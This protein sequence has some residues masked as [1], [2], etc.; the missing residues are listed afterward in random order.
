M[1]LC[2]LC[3]VSLYTLMKNRYTTSILNNKLIRVDMVYCINISISLIYFFFNDTATT[4]IYTYLHTLSLNDALPIFRAFGTLVAHESVVVSTEIPGRVAKIGFR[5]A[6]RVEAGDVLIELD[7]DILAAELAKARSDLSLAT[8]NHERARTLAQQGTGT[9][10]AR[11]EAEAAFHAASANLV[12]AEARLSKSV[13]TAPF[14]GVVGFREVSIGAYV[15]PGDHIVQLAS[16]DPLKV[17]FRV[18]EVFLPHLRLG[19]PV[20]VTVD[21]RPGESIVGEIIAVDPIIDVRSEEG[22]VGKECGSTCR[23][24]WSPDP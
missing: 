10:R 21:A 7:A 20:H 11:D 17:E 5:E 2:N 16:T 12:L 9:L 3:H 8:A 22:R 13:V 18:S 1:P 19:L 24:R 14:A 4:E 15:S 6:Q 23:S